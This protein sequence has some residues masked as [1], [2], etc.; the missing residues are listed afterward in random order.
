MKFCKCALF[1]L[2]P[3]ILMARDTMID[4]TGIVENP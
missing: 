1:L 4:N 3:A 2:F